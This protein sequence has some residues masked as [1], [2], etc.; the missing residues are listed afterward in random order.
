[1]MAVGLDRVSPV[2]MGSQLRYSEERRWIL[3]GRLVSAPSGPERRASAWGEWAIAA[4]WLDYAGALKA[5]TESVRRGKMD[6]GF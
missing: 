5:V 2:F 4:G 3:A 6:V 1:M